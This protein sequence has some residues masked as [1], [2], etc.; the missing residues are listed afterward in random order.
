M[1]LYEDRPRA[2]ETPLSVGQ[3]VTW[4]HYPRQGPKIEIP[5]TVVRV[6]HPWYWVDTENQKSIKV[7]RKYLE[8]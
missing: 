6:E 5:A 7:N 3:R 4:V 1:N 8:V 2:E